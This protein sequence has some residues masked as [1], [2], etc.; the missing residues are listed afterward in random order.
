M[1]TRKQWQW[2][3]LWS[4]T[5]GAVLLLMA[6]EPGSA[7]SAR[8]TEVTS[9]VWETVPRGTL[10]PS[11]T[12]TYTPS[13]S[14]T[15]TYTPSPS[16]T[17]T[18]TPQPTSTITPTATPQ[19][20]GERALGRGQAPQRLL[21][22]MLDNHPH[23]YPQTGMDA[24]VLVFEALAEYGITRFMAVFA[25]GIS[26]HAEVIGPVR[27]ARDYFVQWAMGM[28]AVY[29]HA[30]GSP[31]GLWLASTASE[32]TDMDALVS[33][34][35][36][37]FYRSRARYAPHNLYTDSDLLNSFVVDKGVG[38]FDP[39]ETG[40]LFKHDA[41]PAARG[42]SQQMSYYFVYPA[43]PAGWI[44]DAE[45]N[46]Y[47]RTRRGS[48]H[49]DARTGEQLWFKNVIIL[50]VVKAPIPGDPKQRIRQEVVGEGLA[51]VFVDGIEQ[52][53]HWKKPTASDPLRFYGPDN[54]EILLNA[55]PVWI[56]A[57]PDMDN[58]TVK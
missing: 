55:G 49:I 43:D 15:A 13:P 14:P 8:L 1:R 38:E 7:Q 57:I 20:T 39:S 42:T 25:P 23:A 28:N 53:A 46:G 10:S 52:E 35:Q 58:L 17:G 4:F 33:Y 34:A 31:D 36:P 12:P 37:Y 56:A 30:G 18:L 51:R 29:A 47:Y 45:T 27:S 40:F 24:S 6:C 26:P 32:I 41:P 50:E 21:A 44:Y 2:F 19:P 5:L 16:P 48:P 9:T 3:F 11:P 22:V 54:Q